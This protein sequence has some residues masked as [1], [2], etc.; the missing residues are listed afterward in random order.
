[1]TQQKSVP[2]NPYDILGVSSAASKAE[3]TKAFILAMKRKEYPVDVIAHA[4]KSLMNPEKRII[5]D[6]L[7]P[8]LPTIKRFKCQDLSGIENLNYELNLL[9]EFDNLDIES[10]ID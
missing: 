8:I 3:I 5:A 4:N 6:Y 9:D 7:R 2:Q 1:M 10:T